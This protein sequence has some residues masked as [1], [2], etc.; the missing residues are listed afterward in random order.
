MSYTL[1]IF[2]LI[3]NSKFVPV[4]KL[5]YVRCSRN[6]I[7]DFSTVNFIIDGTHTLKVKLL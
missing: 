3:K 4:I 2:Y 5:D 1:L 6:S 7:V